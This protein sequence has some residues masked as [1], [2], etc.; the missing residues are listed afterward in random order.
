[1][2]RLSFSFPAAPERGHSFVTHTPNKH[3]L[4][5][6]DPL[7]AG[8]TTGSTSCCVRA[9]HGAEEMSS[10]SKWTPLKS[11]LLSESKKLSQTLIRESHDSSKQNLVY[12]QGHRRNENGWQ[13]FVGFRKM[14]ELRVRMQITASRW[15]YKQR[16]PNIWWFLLWE[17]SIF[18]E[19]QQDWTKLFK[20]QEKRW[21]ND[22]ISI[23]LLPGDRNLWTKEFQG[24]LL[25]PRFW[26]FYPK[27]EMNLK[28]LELFFAVGQR[29]RIRW[30]M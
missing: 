19:I 14:E 10:L 7:G 28:A 2:S 11:A 18:S 6:S 23:I 1:M 5:G 25:C 17:P 4:L 12:P 3:A 22:D 30:Q 27:Y 20:V 8:G 9:Q 24:D 29:C 13:F 21:L 15:H 26:R 16:S